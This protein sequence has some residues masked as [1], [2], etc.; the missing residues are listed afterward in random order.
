[1]VCVELTDLASGLGSRARWTPVVIC[2]A[3]KE[4]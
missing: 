3:A 2:E 4:G 1:M